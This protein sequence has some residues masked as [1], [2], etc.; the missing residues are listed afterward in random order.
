MVVKRE[1][2]ALNLEAAMFSVDYDHDILNNGSNVDKGEYLCPSNMKL[3]IRDDYPSPDIIMGVANENKKFVTQT[4]FSNDEITVI[5]FRIIDDSGNPYSGNNYNIGYSPRIDDVPVA[6]NSDAGL[7]D[8]EYRGWKYDN[9]CKKDRKKSK[10]IYKPKTSAQSSSIGAIVAGKFYVWILN[11]KGEK[12]SDAYQVNVLPSGLDY[13][14]YIAMI[15]DLIHIKRELIVGKSKQSVDVYDECFHDLLSKID[16]LCRWLQ[17]INKNPKTYLKQVPSKIASHKIKKY[18][19]KIIAELYNNPHKPRFNS[20]RYDTSVDIYE[21]RFLYNA[22]NKLK[23]Y[24]NEMLEEYQSEKEK[25]RAFDEE[26]VKKIEKVIGLQLNDVSEYIL[27]K[28]N[29]MLGIAEYRRVHKTENS[30]KLNMYKIEL[31]VRVTRNDAFRKEVCI[32]AH[33]ESG[34]YLKISGW[35]DSNKITNNEKI[36]LRLEDKKYG[37]WQ[38]NSNAKIEAQFNNLGRIDISLKTFDIESIAALF[39]M[40]SNVGVYTLTCYIKEKQV[41]FYAPNDIIASFSRTDSNGARLYNHDLKIVEIE[42]IEKESVN[43]NKTI[44]FDKNKILGSTRDIETTIKNLNDTFPNKLYEAMLN[45]IKLINNSND[46]DIDSVNID[47]IKGKIVDNLERLSKLDIFKDFHYNEYQ[48]LRW[49][50][51]QIFANDLFYRNAYNL[52]QN[53]EHTYYFSMNNSKK[54]IVTDKVDVLY[55]YWLLIKFL[56]I[57]VKQLRWSFSEQYMYEDD[58]KKI[59]E[60]IESFFKLSKKGDK[61]SFGTEDGYVILYHKLKD[62]NKPLVMELHYDTPIVNEK[63]PDFRFYFYVKNGN[64]KEDAFNVYADAKYR[65]YN[66][67]GSITQ[68][69]DDIGDVSL[70]KYTEELKT[71]KFYSSTA[72][73]IIHSDPESKYRYWGNSINDPVYNKLYEL[74]PSYKRLYGQPGHRYGGF[75]MI[76]SDYDSFITF[77]KMI[78]EYHG[79]NDRSMLFT[80][81]CCEC[82]G[83]DINVETVVKPG[84]RGA[85]YYVTC[86]NSECGAFWVKNHCSGED[87]DSKKPHPLYKHLIHNFQN[88]VDKE[89]DWMV[90]CPI[91]GDRGSLNGY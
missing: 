60:K 46:S 57:L 13:K 64:F 62:S 25:K 37:Y 23:H 90:E 12:V 88:L 39:D 35:I 48:D 71:D 78:V 38:P 31:K 74:Y 89:Y 45:S 18:N 40:V 14:N 81:M 79:S 28:N 21:N 65:L 51:T 69:A 86:N 87:K 52:L 73:F 54:S 8:A 7:V 5:A 34:F 67:M 77:M 61:Y 19:S 68:F 2:F 91:C 16:L 29:V 10:F 42:K 66:N 27:A 53:L 76:P 3:L 24:I 41:D 15:D 30:S 22:I 49:N 70:R 26:K 9:S 85:T 58:I 84:R 47:D 82:G 83:T 59:A 33:N 6:F 56:Y 50:R 44:I 20:I 17:T 43:G 36:L 75:C 32:W 11:E 80:Q 63:R 1:C 4:H 72:S 55:E